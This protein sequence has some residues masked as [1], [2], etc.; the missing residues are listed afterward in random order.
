MTNQFASMNTNRLES[1]A[2]MSSP[3][4]F[5]ISWMPVSSLTQQTTASYFIKLGWQFLDNQ[6]HIQTKQITI[7]Q[8]G[9]NKMIRSGHMLAAAEC[10]KLNLI[11]KLWTYKVLQC[12]TAYSPTSWCC[13]CINRKVFGSPSQNFL[14]GFWSLFFFILLFITFGQTELKKTKVYFLP[15]LANNVYLIMSC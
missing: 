13:R 12:W 15:S 2:W 8:E 11:M 9:L 6:N 3:S 1:L 5:F 7:C 4:S 14:L 10:F